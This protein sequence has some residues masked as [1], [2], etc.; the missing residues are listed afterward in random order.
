LNILPC[1]ALRIGLVDGW[2]DIKS[3]SHSIAF[4][5][6]IRPYI[7]EIKMADLS[8]P[9]LLIFYVGAMRFTEAQEHVFKPR[10]DISR[11]PSTGSA[12][13]CTVYSSAISSPPFQYSVPLENIRTSEIKV[14]SS[15]ALN[16]SGMQVIKSIL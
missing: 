11:T 12:T 2:A 4:L 7:T 3:S 6:R 9:Q 16:A 10:K 14:E 5:I 13:R 15:I 1:T 8:A